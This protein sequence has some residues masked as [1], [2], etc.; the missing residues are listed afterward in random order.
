VSWID[1]DFKPD[2][3]IGDHI[4]MVDNESSTMKNQDFIQTKWIDGDFRAD[5]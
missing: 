3:S 2:D 4:K 5:E 1:G